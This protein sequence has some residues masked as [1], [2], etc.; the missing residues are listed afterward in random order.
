MKQ[1]TLFPALFALAFSACAAEPDFKAAYADFTQA[2][3]GFPKSEL[4]LTFACL[5][6]AEADAVTVAVDSG[7]M[8]LRFDALGRLFSKTLSAKTREF[9]PDYYAGLADGLA[10][11]FGLLGR[12]G[13][14]ASDWVLANEDFEAFMT[15]R[16][17]DVSVT[18]TNLRLAFDGWRQNLRTDG[19]LRVRVPFFPTAVSVGETGFTRVKK[20]VRCKGKAASD[21][22]AVCRPPKLGRDGAV[23]KTFAGTD[24]VKSVSVTS[25]PAQLEQIRRANPKLAEVGDGLLAVAGS[26]AL[27]GVRTETS[28]DGRTVLTF[29]AAKPVTDY[30]AHTEAFGA[31]RAE[32]E[33]LREPPAP[34]A[35][36]AKP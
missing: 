28:A 16:R 29:F 31:F 17:D 26:E 3:I 6:S 21:E 2:R 18:V 8:T 20:Q 7:E 12:Q 22:G 14:Y 10:M 25:T 35:S 11:R 36:A 15:V 5:P 4:C 32:V 27:G 24:V 30:Y 1:L 13:A 9:S 33:K 23:V 34:S 19:S